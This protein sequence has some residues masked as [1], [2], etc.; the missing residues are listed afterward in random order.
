MLTDLT[1]VP[2][3]TCPLVTIIQNGERKEV[4]GKWYSMYQWKRYCFCSFYWYSVEF[5]W[6]F[7]GIWFQHEILHSP[8]EGSWWWQTDL[9]S[10]QL[11]VIW[12][13]PPMWISYSHL[14]EKCRI[15]SM[16]CLPYIAPD[17]RY[18]SSW[19]K[20]RKTTEK[21]SSTQKYQRNG[22]ILALE[23][24][25][26]TFQHGRVP[27]ELSTNFFL[28]PFTLY[29][30]PFIRFI[31]ISIRFSSF[32]GHVGDGCYPIGRQVR[33]RSSVHHSMT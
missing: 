24:L 21:K 1:C 26:F 12:T 5:I 9:I 28:S 4:Q 22:C 16:G 13:V 10:F 3:G 6:Q 19:E 20:N 23:N 31:D 30:F 25:Q 29:N 27:P 7:L 32:Q 11:I 33:S 2:T 8:T 15:L 18:C 17:L 14:C